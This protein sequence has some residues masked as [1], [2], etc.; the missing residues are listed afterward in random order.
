MPGVSIKEWKIVKTWP[1]NTVPKIFL[2]WSLLCFSFL[3]IQCLYIG[4]WCLEQPMYK[5]YVKSLKKKKMLLNRIQVSLFLCTSVYFFVIWKCSFLTHAAASSVSLCECWDIAEGQNIYF[6]LCPPL[7]S[8]CI[9]IMYFCFTTIT[10]CH[11]CFSGSNI[12]RATCK[13][14]LMRFTIKTAILECTHRLSWI[15]TWLV[16]QHSLL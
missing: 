11:S 13:W 9:Y 4:I 5:G 2:K 16:F 10:H 8:I 3:P 1:K 6:I 12:F 7:K 14:S 15:L